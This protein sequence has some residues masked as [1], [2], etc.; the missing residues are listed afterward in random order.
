[1]MD[2]LAIPGYDRR[3]LGQN[4][5]EVVQQGCGSSYGCTK[6]KADSAAKEM[7]S[8]L[9]YVTIIEPSV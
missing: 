3:W 8:L 4:D 2:F 5:E 1:M 6:R 9:A 7:R